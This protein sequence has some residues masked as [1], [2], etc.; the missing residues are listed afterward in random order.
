MLGRDIKI[1]L[2]QDNSYTPMECDIK[3][4]ENI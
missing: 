1:S 3:D 4:N 2:L